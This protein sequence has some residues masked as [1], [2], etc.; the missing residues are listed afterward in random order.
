MPSWY[1]H[2]ASCICLSNFPIFLELNVF[3]IIDCSEWILLFNFVNEFFDINVFSWDKFNFSSPVSL[4]HIE[5][6]HLTFVPI[7]HSYL[8]MI[9]FSSSGLSRTTYNNLMIAFIF[10]CQYWSILALSVTM[11]ILM[12]IVFMNSLASW[13][14]FILI[15]FTIQW[16]L[17][18]S[19]YESIKVHYFSVWGW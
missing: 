15:I 4:L 18:Q 13:S 10:Y 16:Y 3:K 14:H 6:N 8:I 2:T 1:Y 5:I 11:S 17:E 7:F 12:L 9:T 19:M